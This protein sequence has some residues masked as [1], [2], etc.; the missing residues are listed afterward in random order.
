MAANEQIGTGLVSPFRRDEK[1]D[2]AHSNG[3][4]LLKSDI[5]DLLGLRGPTAS[6][7]GE[8]AWDT[9]R[10]ATFNTLLHRHL[11]GEMV[12]ALANQIAVGVLLKY[13]PRVR[14]G[15]VQAGVNDSDELEIKVSY[16]PLGFLRGPE[17]TVT[18]KV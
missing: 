17:Q 16:T 11:H 14:P 18:K 1:G 6:Q 10:G 15:N 9:E 5:G 7:P 4:D 2:F 13:E 12:N 3:L 8:L